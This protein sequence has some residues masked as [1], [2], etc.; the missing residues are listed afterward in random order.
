[1]M[2]TTELR[3]R[4][5]TRMF[6]HAAGAG[7]P[8]CTD[9]ATRSVPER[10]PD[11]GRVVRVD[12]ADLPGSAFLGQCMAAKREPPCVEV[13]DGPVAAGSPDHHRQLVE[14]RAVQMEC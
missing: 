5:P 8:F 2:R 10:A 1:M 4:R 11:V 3:I 6:H 12:T 13:P 14:K 9:S 7:T